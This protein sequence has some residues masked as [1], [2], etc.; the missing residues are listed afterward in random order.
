[1]AG[2]KRGYPSAF[3]G[4]ISNRANC[5]GNKKAGLAP[6]IQVPI[7][8]LNTAIYSARP[9]N[10]CKI[11]NICYFIPGTRRRQLGG[12]IIWGGILNRP[13]QSKRPPYTG[14]D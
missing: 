12:N 7:N 3:N 14:L 9:P 10:C 5:G 13:V 2:P 1:M 6:T 4:L 11:N 8:I